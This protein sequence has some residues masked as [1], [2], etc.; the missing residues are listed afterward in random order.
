MNEFTVSRTV[1][2]SDVLSKYKECNEAGYCCGARRGVI[3]MQR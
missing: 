3:G 1:V 2:S